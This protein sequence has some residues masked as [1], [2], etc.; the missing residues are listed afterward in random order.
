MGWRRFLFSSAVVMLAMLSGGP[1]PT[2][3]ALAPPAMVRTEAQFPSRRGDLDRTFGA[4]GVVR[5]D[6]GGIDL[7]F[8]VEL[9]LD[10][11][12]LIA[13]Q[14]E[15]N[16]VFHIA[17]ARYTHD[18]RLDPTFGAGGM[19]ITDLGGA[20]A[21]YA[22]S[23]DRVGPSGKIAV[24]GVR[25]RDFVLLRYNPDG[26]LDRGFGSG[27]V[28]I[29]PTS[30]EIA[31]V[32]FDVGIERDESIFVA[33][34]AGFT[35]AHFQPD[36]TLD[37]TFG[38]GGIVPLSDAT[39]D[40]VALGFG[41]RAEG[42]YTI[43]VLRGRFTRTQYQLDGTLNVEFGEGG[44]IISPLTGG[45]DSVYTFL[46][47]RDGRF[48]A[49]GRS[50]GR[51][52]MARYTADLELDV[53]FGANG[54]VIVDAGEQAIEEVYAA[55]VGL[56]NRILLAGGAGGDFAVAQFAGAIAGDILLS[57][58][59]DDP[60]TGRFLRA[61]EP[62]TGFT[63]GYRDAVYVIERSEVAQFPGFNAWAP[64][65]YADSGIA[66]DAR[67][68][69]GVVG[70]SVGVFCRR[71][72][73]GYYAFN[74]NL[75]EG[76][77]D[78]T[79]ARSNQ[80]ATD[81]PTTVALAL[82]FSPV[83]RQGNRSNR[84]ELSCAG[85]TITAIINGTRVSVAQD[86]THQGGAWGIGAGLF[87][88][89]LVGTLAARFDNLVI[90][91][92]VAPTPGTMLIADDFDDPT[93]NI[94]V[95]PPGSA[96]HR[97]EPSGGEYVI[98]K[99]DPR[100][101]PFVAFVPGWFVDAA[102]AFDVR[103]VG[104]MR[105]RYAA[106]QCRRGLGRESDGYRLKLDL[107]RGAVLL[108]RVD[109]EAEVPLASSTAGTI[110]RGGAVNGV[111]FICTGSTI[112]VTVNGVRVA[113]AQD[114]TYREGRF[115]ISVQTEPGLSGGA[116]A[117]FDNLVVTAAR[118]PARGEPLLVDEF[119]RDV[120]GI[121]PSASAAPEQFRVG[122]VNGEY[123]VA[124]SAGWA[125][126]PA[127]LVPG[128]FVDAVLAVDARLVGETMGRSVVLGCR[129]STE[130]PRDGYQL[131]LDPDGGVVTLGIWVQGNYFRMFNEASVA[132]R[133]GGEVNHVE[134]RCSG[135]VI[136][137]VV[138]G[139]LVASVRSTAYRTGWMW[140]GVVADPGVGGLVEAR[141]NNLVVRQD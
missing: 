105:G 20:A 32:V 5:T 49:A 1:R 43:S 136:S 76:T 75:D 79:V 65:L 28:V 99:V 81:Q 74:V 84:I 126:L 83:I 101:P 22:V 98:A 78:L 29:I 113:V 55:F 137:A 46:P 30:G 47:T 51:Y 33:A 129:R 60:S 141:F 107:D 44:Q 135:N 122:Y 16:G 111:E 134:L 70:R 73:A 109:G 24:A 69:G 66:V 94:L 112:I 4:G 140:L 23:P 61:A 13:G 37:D 97:F 124:R 87:G 34:T 18:G 56:D 110:R 36:G 138:N 11:R 102:I 88:N 50:G 118:P 117:R 115:W 77:F 121:L 95:S 132:I 130:S 127:V 80:Q 38:V 92:G 62:E 48:I 104:E 53:T 42:L 131:N 90:T 93:T 14:T 17:L 52:V 25:G 2:L 119:E 86:S 45:I 125:G 85:S 7:A 9:Q 139:T 19:V 40:A 106:A 128:L 54:I 68:D 39:R 100:A 123:L 58:T 103:M 27:G 15:Q 116:E 31:G 10:G 82:G 35:L 89:V 64:G 114:S 57:D 59:F 21:A 12:I 67:L 8:R 6:F 26:S 72:A 108:F 96:T 3:T 63:V 71:S 120:T 41:R 133:Q 91:Q